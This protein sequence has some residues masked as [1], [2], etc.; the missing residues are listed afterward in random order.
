M[1]ELFD[2]P[3]GKTSECCQ[4][5]TQKTA[6]GE[7]CAKC[8][9][10]VGSY[11]PVTWEKEKVKAVARGESVEKAAEAYIRELE[12]DF[13]AVLN[14]MEAMSTRYAEVLDC[15]PT[16]E[17]FD[18]ILHHYENSDYADTDRGLRTHQ[19]VAER[20]RVTRKLKSAA[21]ALDKRSKTESEQPEVKA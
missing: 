2:K 19:I 8:G 13:K 20:I 11:N 15:L 18:L 17:E 10:P 5:P 3:T 6:T 1:S 12:R 4:A 16:P 9:K 21:L 14:V 7:W